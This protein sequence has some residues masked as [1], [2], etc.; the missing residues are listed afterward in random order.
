[1]LDTDFVKEFY[2]EKK[3]NP[4]IHQ[5]VFQGS[6]YIGQLDFWS[7]DEIEE[8]GHMLGITK[9]SLILDIG[10]GLGGPLC[11]LAG[12]SGCKGIGV[13]ISANNIKQAEERKETMGLGNRVS[14]V[15]SDIN[16]AEFQNGKFD[17]IISIDSMVHIK[18]RYELLEKC[19]LW[20]KPGGKLIIAV[21][22]VSKDIPA[23]LLNK[24]NRLGAVFSDT[25]ENYRS[26][27]EKSRFKLIEERIYPRKRYEFAVKA[28]EWMETNHSLEGWDSMNMIKVINELGYAEQHLFLL[29]RDI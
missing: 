4:C 29:E 11:Y 25:A 15:L 16:E 5:Y 12:V 24:R 21:E 22:C 23:E 10:S 27:F 13:D 20:L 3:H 17:F 8:F 9:E 6:Q 26:I 2:S 1:M 18:K 7:A 19:R 28:L 14:F